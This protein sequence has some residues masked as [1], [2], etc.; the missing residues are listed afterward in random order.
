MS[1]RKPCLGYP[2][3]TEAVMALLDQG[4]TPAVIARRI[5]AESGAPITEKMVLDLENSRLR[6]AQRKLGNLTT[7]RAYLRA[8]AKIDRPRVLRFL[9]AM[10]SELEGR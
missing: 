3:R 7:Y 5:E 10:M 1:A 2:S 4:E 9:R 6:Q 8:A